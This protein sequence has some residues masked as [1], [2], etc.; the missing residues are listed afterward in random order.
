MADT[1][2]Q[3]AIIQHN[4]EDMEARGFYDDDDDDEDQTGGGDADDMYPADLDDMVEMRD[5]DDDL[6]D[7]DQIERALEKIRRPEFLSQEQLPKYSPK[8][9]AIL[10]RILDDTHPGLHLVYSSFRTLEGIGILRLVLLNNGFAEFKL[11]KTTEGDWDIDEAASGGANAGKPTFILY[12][13]TETAEEKEMLRNVYNGAWDVLPPNI[14]RKLEARD[15]DGKKNTMG[16]IIRVMMITASGAEGINLKNTRYVHIVEPYW[17]MVR[18]DQVVGRARRI[19][20]HEELPPE[21][22]TV[23]VF[24]YLSVF[25]EKQRKDRNYIELMNQDVSRLDE[26]TPVTTDETLYEISLQKSRINQ[27]ILTVVKQSS[28]DCA[29]YNPKSAG[30][31]EGGLV[32]Y[33]ADMGKLRDTDTEFISYPTLDQDSQV[34]TK[35]VV[36]RATVVYRDVTIQGKKYHMNETTRELYDHDTFI[37]AKKSGETMIPVGTL[38]REGRGYKIVPV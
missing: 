10:E 14:A 13:G 17:N 24:V 31:E 30:K 20:S 27:Q 6:A 18:V 11:V 36:Q 15:P 25:S 26:V 32:C 4:R 2:E 35:T 21:L 19:C 28:V 38:E 33:G 5:D 12:T 7:K 23:Q 34:Q 16:G 9:A 8:F 22:R 1:Q 29:L 37:R 3:D